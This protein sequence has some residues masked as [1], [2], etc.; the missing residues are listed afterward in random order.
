MYEGHGQAKP[1]LVHIIW[2]E[3]QGTVKTEPQG[4]M[5]TENCVMLGV[6]TFYFIELACCTFSSSLALL[7]NA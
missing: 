1:K 5:Y 2:G 3:K 7:G 4:P 6:L